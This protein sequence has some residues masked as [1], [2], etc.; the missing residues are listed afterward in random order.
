M[1]RIV[2]RAPLTI[3]EKYGGDIIATATLNNPVTQRS[4][5][6]IV[7]RSCAREKVM[8]I[9]GTTPI[10]FDTPSGKQIWINGFGL[11]DMTALFLIDDGL[12]QSVWIY[13]YDGSR[14]TLWFNSPY[15]T[16]EVVSRI[17][18]SD[19]TNVDGD[20]FVL[21]ADLRSIYHIDT[22]GREV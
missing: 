16:P 1:E 21:T 8:L 18:K 19:I 5:G 6:L 2:P 3:Q 20:A 17:L 14:A 11:L 4:D 12:S 9:L 22:L 13:R 15:N 7:L 10:V